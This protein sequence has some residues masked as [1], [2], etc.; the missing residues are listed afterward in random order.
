MSKRVRITIEFVDADARGVT[1]RY[2]EKYG[3]VITEDLGGVDQIAQKA[4]DLVYHRI[5][6]SWP[7][8]LEES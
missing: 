6:L 8:F 7:E 5:G 4:S 1:T 3:A 2:G